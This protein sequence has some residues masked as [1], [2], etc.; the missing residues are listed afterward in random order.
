MTTSTGFPKFPHGTPLTGDI[1]R[2][3]I[4]Y[5]PHGKGQASMQRIEEGFVIYREAITNGEYHIHLSNPFSH[6]EVG[7]TLIRKGDDWKCN[8]LGD[9]EHQ[10]AMTW[11]PMV[12]FRQSR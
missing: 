2:M 7:R 4:S 6:L 8:W 9:M 3:E 5:W 1:V 10:V 12:E 11:R